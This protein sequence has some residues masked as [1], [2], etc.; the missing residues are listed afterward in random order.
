[1]TRFTSLTL[2]SVMALSLAACASTP[3]P[4]PIEEPVAVIVPEVIDT[5][6][7]ISALKRVVIP[8]ETKVFYAITEIANPPYEPIQRTEKV[9]REIK[10]AE[11]IY[12]DTEGRQ[13]LPEAPLNP[14][15][16]SLSVD[17]RSRH[18]LLSRDNKTARP[19]FLRTP[20]KTHGDHY[21]QS[22]AGEEK[23]YRVS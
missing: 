12:V 9:E 19:I 7:P 15:A 13:V 21:L 5:C 1:M 18:S 16:A 14:R 22:R 8:A 20:D 3:E 2:A 6:T 10:P 11:V 4:E 17:R 23:V